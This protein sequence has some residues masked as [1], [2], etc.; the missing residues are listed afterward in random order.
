MKDAM[1][2]Q[3]TSS[4]DFLV[5]RID[6]STDSAERKA[7]FKELGECVESFSRFSKKEQ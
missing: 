2:E 3:F 5:H 7:L 1:K 6:I 4:M